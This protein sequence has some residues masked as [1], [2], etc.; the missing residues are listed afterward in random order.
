MPGWSRYRPHSHSQVS[1]DFASLPSRVIGM[2]LDAPVVPLV[3]VNST[4]GCL[5]SWLGSPFIALVMYGSRSS[6]CATGTRSWYWENDVMPAN[7]CR[8]PNAL[9]ALVRRIS[10]SRRSRDS[11]GERVTAANFRS[12]NGALVHSNSRPTRDISSPP[13]AG[14]R[15]LD[16]VHRPSPEN[17]LVHRHPEAGAHRA[18]RRAAAEAEPHRR[19]RGILAKQVGS[20][21]AL[22]VADAGVAPGQ[23]GQQRDMRRGQQRRLTHLTPDLEHQAGV[24]CLP[25]PG[26]RGHQAAALGDPDVDGGT[27][28]AADQRP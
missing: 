8:R 15:D 2:Y 16:R 1:R 11:T 18:A 3:V 24:Q 25:R 5:V 22:R 9:P 6:Y 28:A 19:G 10:R 13:F 17:R 26:G 20:E 14:L 12:V 21:A 23:G 7:S 4:G 27:G